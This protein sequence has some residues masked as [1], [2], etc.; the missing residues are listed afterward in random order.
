MYDF[1]N[2]HITII[3][4]GKNISTNEITISEYR[5]TLLIIDLLYRNDVK[6]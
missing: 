2:I 3:K 4:D 6:H 1:E 5:K